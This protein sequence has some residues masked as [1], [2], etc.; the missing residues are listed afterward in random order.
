MYIIIL[1]Y[2]YYNTSEMQGLVRWAW[3]TL[4]HIMILKLQNHVRLGMT[5]KCWLDEDYGLHAEH[6]DPPAN[7]L[8]TLDYT[9][10]VLIYA[11][12]AAGERSYKH[13]YRLQQLKCCLAWETSL[14]DGGECCP[15]ICHITLRCIYIT[16]C[17]IW[18]VSHAR[19]HSPV[20]A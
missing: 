1:L 17:S 5:S 20:A 16:N 14:R 7:T 15:D 3:A 13:V 2:M 8:V 19:Q 4:H 11:N 12:E 10:L 9:W 18:P 6:T